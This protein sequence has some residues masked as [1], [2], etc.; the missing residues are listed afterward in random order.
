MPRLVRFRH[1]GSDDCPRVG[2]LAYEPEAVIS[3]QQLV[4]N[5]P[6]VVVDLS[7]FGGGDL[8]MRQ[9]LES[10]D[11][12]LAYAEELALS[13][14]P[15]I[16]VADVQ[17]LSPVPDPEK[18]ICIGLNYSDHAKECGLALPA[19]PVVFSKF[20]NAIIGPDDDILMP[21][22]STKVDY[23]V[24][25]VMVIG[26][27]ACCV[28]EEEAMDYVVGYTVGNDVSARDWQLEWGGSQW[29]TGK[30]F[31]TF[32]PTGPAIVTKDLVGDVDNLGI[33]CYV[34]GVPLQDSTTSYLHFKCPFIVSHLSHLMTLQPGDLI[35]TGTPPGVA[36][37]RTPHCWL[38]PGDVVCCEIERVGKITN[39]CTAK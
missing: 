20:N 8:T 10:G 11:E 27:K 35:F 33:S 16:P 38:Q 19:K 14:G 39:K 18:L 37:G 23:E 31:D 28:T 17:I 15:K 30:T 2:A 6:N 1:K 29:L 5:E 32:A 34:N 4:E 22:N 13:G 3:A 9:F 24:E 25:L 7:G 36:L 26:K 12:A 21:P